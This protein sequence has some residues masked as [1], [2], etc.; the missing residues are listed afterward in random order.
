MSVLF[1]ALLG[2]FAL[3]QAAPNIQVF[4]AGKAAGGRVLGMMYR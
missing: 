4:S 1:A 3:G 2:G